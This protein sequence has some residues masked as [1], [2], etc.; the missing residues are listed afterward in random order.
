MK[1]ILFATDFS[2]NAERALDFALNLARNHG[3]E[4]T[5]LHVFDIPTSWNYP[6][7]ETALEMERQA[8]RNAEKNLAELFQNHTRSDEILRANYL[9]IGNRSVVKGILEGIEE[10]GAEILIVGTK[11]ES[12]VK[13][14]LVGSTTK[15]MLN[16]SPVPILAIPENITKVSFKKVV[17]A[18]D[19]QTEDL[20]A[21]TQSISF[22]EPFHPEITIIHISRYD[23]IVSAE[24]VQFFK[25]QIHDLIKYP[26]IRIEILYA[27]KTGK[28]ILNYLQQNQVDLLIMLEKDRKGLWDNLFHPDL[29]KKMEFH[30]HIPVL[31]FSEKHLLH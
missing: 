31:S 6:H 7:A 8:V 10:S 9:V 24:F 15:A 23:D 5:M 21:L 16:D 2:E 20:R 25:S 13:E 3:A 14:L 11:G 28:S 19:F 30:S 12:K 29:V 4:I 17:F 26:N 18:S 27:D 22:L 1:N